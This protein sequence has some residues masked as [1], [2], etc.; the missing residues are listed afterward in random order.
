MS[1]WPK[2]FWKVKSY[3]PYDKYGSL[4]NPTK[5]H[6]NLTNSSWDRVKKVHWS[7]FFSLNWKWDVST[8]M[9]FN[10][11]KG[12]SLILNFFLILVFIECRIWINS[13]LL[14]VKT[15]YRL[16]LIKY[17]FFQKSTKKFCPFGLS[18]NLWTWGT[19]MGY[20][21]HILDMSSI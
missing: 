19:I 14:D 16:Y 1:Q 4:I 13:Y 10:F 3:C 21:Y 7:P 9:T 17:K 11:T 12:R 2:P 6:A 15:F 18:Q 8:S 5:F 20:W